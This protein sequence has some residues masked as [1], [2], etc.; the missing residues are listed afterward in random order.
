[1]YVKQIPLTFP[2]DNISVDF[3]YRCMPELPAAPSPTVFRDRIPP[4]QAPAAI[5]SPEQRQEA[6]IKN[7]Q[8]RSAAFE[9]LVD[10]QPSPATL[11]EHV[12]ASAQ[13]VNAATQEV[14]QAQNATNVVP[15]SGVNR[16]GFVRKLFG[17][18]SE[19][20]QKI[21]VEQATSSLEAAVAQQ[22]QVQSDAEAAQMYTSDYLK[23]QTGER[24]EELVEANRHGGPMGVSE[25]M[26][27]ALTYQERVQ[28]QVR[29]YKENGYDLKE[30]DMLP[31]ETYEEIKAFI[32]REKGFGGRITEGEALTAMSAINEVALEYADS[33][34]IPVDEQVLINA[35]T[36]GRKIVDGVMGSDSRAVRDFFSFR[37]ES[38]HFSINEIGYYAIGSFQLDRFFKRYNIPEGEARVPYILAYSAG[39]L[40]TD[41]PRIVA[42]I[43][44][45]FIADTLPY[46]EMR[47]VRKNSEWTEEVQPA[48]SRGLGS[49]I[50]PR[51][52]N[53]SWDIQMNGTKDKGLAD[54]MKKAGDITRDIDS[55]FKRRRVASLVIENF[56]INNVRDPQ[57]VS[58]QAVLPGF[59][60]N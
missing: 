35:Y 55:K 52:P 41:A 42:P 27:Q 6:V 23:K 2:I 40:T 31:L 53:S 36:Q 43:L 50:T 58:P 46:E 38:E 5:K 24:A 33:H 17:K 1:M 49:F 57:V 48:K 3:Y 21:S 14:V 29:F 45:D 11:G 44:R 9:P 34:G 13:A 25:K 39:A 47:R 30:G 37:K 16:L 59:Q 18:Q 51:N 7:I 20:E 28:A 26:T 10:T 8:N 22:Q 54:V 19:P 32:G 56:G 60:F 15:E 4:S 12:A